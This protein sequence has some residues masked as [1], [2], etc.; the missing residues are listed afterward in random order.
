MKASRSSFPEVVENGVVEM[1][2]VDWSL[3]TV[4]SRVTAPDAEPPMNESRAKPSKGKSPFLFVAKIRAGLI[5]HL[6]ESYG[7]FFN[8]I[9]LAPVATT[10]ATSLRPTGPSWCLRLN[11]E[12]LKRAWKK[13]GAWV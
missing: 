1:A 3:E 4:A 10:F 11:S 6:M 9:A 8:R 2:E 5:V 7:K 13:F 12:H